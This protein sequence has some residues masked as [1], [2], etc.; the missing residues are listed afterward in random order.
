MKK[1]PVISAAE[2]EVMKVIWNNYPVST[3]EVVDKLMETSTW[4]P[5]TVQTLLSRLVKKGVL[6]FSKN[7][8]VFV[9]T[10]VYTEDMYLSQESSVFLDKFFGG[11]FNSMVVNFLENDKL[12]KDDIEELRNLL[13]GKLGK[14]D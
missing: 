11:T 10:P 1:L 13:D 5:K 14:G 3:N 12:S 4:N 6:T 2:Y 8:R 7:S 9:Y